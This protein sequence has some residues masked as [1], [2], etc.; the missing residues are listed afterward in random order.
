MDYEAVKKEFAVRASKRATADRQEQKKL[1]RKLRS[2]LRSINQRKGELRRELAELDK[3]QVIVQEEVALSTNAKLTTRER[4]RLEKLRAVPDDR[5]C[6]ICKEIKYTT[7]QW[8]HLPN[9]GSC[10]CRKCWQG[11]LNE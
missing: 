11:R 1:C 2:V 5:R 4:Q 10:I 7:R 3:Q 8:V 9:E 6:P